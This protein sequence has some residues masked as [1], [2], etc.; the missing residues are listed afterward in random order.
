MVSLYSSF[1]DLCFLSNLVHIFSLLFFNFHCYNFCCC[2]WQKRMGH[3]FVTYVA[4]HLFLSILL[5]RTT[6]IYLSY[7]L[8]FRCTRSYRMV[9][10]VKDRN[11]TCCRNYRISPSWTF[12][13]LIWICNLIVTSPVLYWLSFISFSCWFKKS[14]GNW[15]AEWLGRLLLDQKVQ[16]LIPSSNL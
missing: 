10:R 11:E 14:L 7:C 9:I 8:I 16:S 15:M 6:P 2:L 13:S 4:G 1:I 3:W 5:T 12:Q